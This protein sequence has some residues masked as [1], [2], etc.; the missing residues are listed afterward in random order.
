M[1]DWKID[2]GDSYSPSIP[3]E[4]RE[5]ISIQLGAGFS[6]PKGYPTG[7]RLNKE[8]LEFDKENVEFSNDGKL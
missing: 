3:L 5:S 7:D 6:V 8:I 1:T 2:L 4:G